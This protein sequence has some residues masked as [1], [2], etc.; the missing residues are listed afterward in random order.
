MH[1]VVLPFETADSWFHD[2]DA[3]RVAVSVLVPVFNEELAIESTIQRIH[4]AL[5]DQQF[6]VEIIVVNDGSRDGT[7]EI[8]RRMDGVTVIEHAGNRGY[9]ASLKT[10]IRH[11]RH[12]LIAIIDADGT[13]PIERLPELLRLMDD[14]DMVVGARTGKRVKYPLLRCVPKWFLVRFAEWL[15]RRRIPDLNSGMRVF[16]KSVAER[17]LKIFPDGFSFTTTITVAMLTNGYRVHFEP[18]DYFTRVGRSKIHPLRDTWRIAQV[19]LRTSMYFAPLRVFFPVA[20]VFFLGF[21]GA[22]TADLV[23]GDLTERTLLLLVASV[24]LGMFSLLADLIANRS[25]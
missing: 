1:P 8:L 12:P 24:Q 25:A 17:F 5:D 6:D 2:P 10:G 23:A 13:Y 11:A 21:L 15:T 19:I 18:I 14:A 22:L 9:G 16:R 4:A 3:T 20:M 7:A